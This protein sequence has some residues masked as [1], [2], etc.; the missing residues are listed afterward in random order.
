MIVKYVIKGKLTGLNM[1]TRLNRAH[2]SAGAQEKE[3]MDNYIMWQLNPLQRILKPV[4]VIIT[5][6]EPNRMRDPDNI[7]SAKKFILDAL[8]KRGVL[9]NDG[10]KQI[11]SFADYFKVDKENPR[12]EVVLK[13]I[14]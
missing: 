6:C 8:V 7:A 11:V 14:K 1:Y 5:W 2:W 3:C 13:E 9:E 4:K 12:V 10:W